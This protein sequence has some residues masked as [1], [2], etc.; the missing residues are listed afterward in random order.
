MPSS[1]I[2]SPPPVPFMVTAAETSSIL[3][4]VI[5]I[6][7]SPTRSRSSPSELTSVL[8]RLEI[9]ASPS[10][11]V[12]HERFASCLPTSVVTHPVTR[13]VRSSAYSRSL[14]PVT[15]RCSLPWTR[16]ASSPEIRASLFPAT[17]FMR[18]PPT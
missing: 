12:S 11:W 4:A 1:E 7:L 6:Q 13:V 2:A 3:S 15:L 14:V 17:T 10:A 16:V 5:R 18:F 8:S 9:F